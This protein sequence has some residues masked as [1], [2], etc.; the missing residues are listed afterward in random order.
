MPFRRGK[1]GRN[2][3]GKRSVTRRGIILLF[4]LGAFVGERGPV[5]HGTR[6][7]GRGPGGGKKVKP[8]PGKNGSPFN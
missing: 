1:K 3:R 4:T 8:P 7:G 5:E 6:R 2:G